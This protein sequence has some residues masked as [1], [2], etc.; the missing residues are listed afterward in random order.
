LIAK[1]RIALAKHEVATGCAAA[2]QALSLRPPDDP[3]IGW[4]HAEA[5]EVY[6][7]CLA[8]RGQIGQARYQ[9]QS[10]LATLKS[11]RGV[12]HW[13]TSQVGEDLRALP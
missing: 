4:R 7:Q 3:T 1:A 11:V 10:A 8:A 5:Q 2:R 9:L 6:G 12:D 13:M